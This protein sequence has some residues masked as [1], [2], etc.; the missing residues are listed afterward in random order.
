MSY[1]R[2]TQERVRALIRDELQDT[3][4]EFRRELKQL[5]ENL[6]ETKQEFSRQVQKIRDEITTLEISLIKR[7]NHVAE[8]ANAG[9]NNKQLMVLKTEMRNQVSKEITEQVAPKLA[10]LANYIDQKIVDDSE[11][12]VEWRKRVDAADRATGKRI[13]NG[14]SQS[15]GI[16]YAFND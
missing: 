11:M 14:Q 13:T 7:I 12:V 9:N 5:K 15:S 8:T 2:E 16:E 4:G 6:S 3:H 1:T 10:A